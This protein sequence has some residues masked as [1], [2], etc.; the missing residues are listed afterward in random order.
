M[1]CRWDSTC[2]DPWP[3][4]QSW[5]STPDP[6]TGGFDDNSNGY[7]SIDVDTTSFTGGL[8]DGGTECAG[9]ATGI[10]V[11]GGVVTGSINDISV[12]SVEDHG[13]TLDGESTINGSIECDDN[14]FSGGIVG[15][16]G[17]IFEPLLPTF[18]LPWSRFSAAAWAKRARHDCEHRDTCRRLSLCKAQCSPGVLPTAASSR[19]LTNERSL[20]DGNTRSTGNVSDARLVVG[21]LTPPF[22]DRQCEL[23]R[24]CFQQ[25]PQSCANTSASPAHFRGGLS[26]LA[27]LLM[28]SDVWRLVA[29]RSM[30]SKG[31]ALGFFSLFIGGTL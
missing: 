18:L 2:T 13:I 4:R 6:L 28:L 5:L 23:L 14:I 29:L 1:T 12:I 3:G 19:R 9:A 10:I 27:A 30:R 20:I 22:R 8:T 26:L 31:I 7:S 24:R 15:S 25:R 21:H 17:K 11:T 16:A